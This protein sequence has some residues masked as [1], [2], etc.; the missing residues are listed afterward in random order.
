MFHSTEVALLPIFLRQGVNMIHVLSLV[1]SG[2]ADCVFPASIGELL[3][4]NITSGNPHQVHGFD[5]RLVPGSANFV[6][7]INPVTGGFG[8]TVVGKIDY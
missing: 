3:G 6:V 5:N 4:I 2:S 7:S 8:L 1:D